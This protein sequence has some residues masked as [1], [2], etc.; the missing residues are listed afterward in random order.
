MLACRCF[1]ERDA[2]A[3]GAKLVPLID[4]LRHSHLGSTP[5]AVVDRTGTGVAAYS[6]AAVQ[7]HAQV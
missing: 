1:V 7:R 2:S 5:S 3:P 4:M 6:R